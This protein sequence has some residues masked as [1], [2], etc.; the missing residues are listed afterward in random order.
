M[1]RWLRKEQGAGMMKR[2][3]VL[4]CL[5]VV[6][7]AVA[8]TTGC[9]LLGGGGKDWLGTGSG[10]SYVQ[11]RVNGD[12]TAVDDLKYKTVVGNG[13]VE[14]EVFVSIPV[15]NNR[16]EHEGRQHKITGTFTAPNSCDVVIKN[17]AGTFPFTATPN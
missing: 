14:A 3:D 12:S 2:R 11:F 13:A 7:V 9:E 8:L 6:A 17:T 1:Q 4:R 16:F 15:T 10:G 5:F